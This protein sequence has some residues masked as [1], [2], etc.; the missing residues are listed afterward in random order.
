MKRLN[1]TLLALITFALVS[2]SNAALLLRN[3]DFDADP[4]LG[5]ADDSV[6]APTFWFTGST[7]PQSWN[8]FRFGNDGNGGWNNNGIALGQ[9]YLGPSFDPGPEVGY[10]YTSLGRYAGEISAILQGFAYNRVNGNAAGSFEVGFY[11]TSAGTFSGAD[12]S[13][14]SASGVLLSSTTVDIS[15]L[16]GNTARSQLFDLSATL[17]G[18]GISNGD[19]IWLHIGDGPDNGDLN[20]FDE[21]IIDNLALTV[22]IPEPSSL[23]LALMGG[24]LALV[25]ALVRRRRSAN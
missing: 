21:P 15:A 11:Y 7:V 17:A 1:L 20:T 23:T 24:T 12:G 16:T 19:E 9:D 4:D 25:V 13:D 2:T 5:G 6:A 18:S 14:V 22:V 3:G 8:D 10:F